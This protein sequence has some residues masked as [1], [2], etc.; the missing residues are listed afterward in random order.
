MK[1]RFAYLLL[2]ILTASTVILAQSQKNLTK[3]ETQ[4][5]L[6][7]IGS[8][9]IGLKKSAMYFAGYYKVVEAAE[10]LKNEMHNNAD[11]SIQILAA[12]SLFEIGD[13]TVLN[14]LQSLVNNSQNN[15]KVRKMAKAIYEHW[16]SSENKVTAAVR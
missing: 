3:N 14:D 6:M 15:I 1:R 11:P 16:I 2:A 5:L 4:N 10:A 8:D 12:L 13:D 9:N 7:A